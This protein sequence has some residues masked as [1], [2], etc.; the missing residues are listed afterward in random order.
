MPFS[1]A[2]VNLECEGRVMQMTRTTGSCH[3]GC[4]YRQSRGHGKS[5]KAAQRSN[6]ARA[7]GIFTASQVGGMAGPEVASEGPCGLS[8]GS[9]IVSSLVGG[10]QRVWGQGQCSQS[11]CLR[12]IILVTG[13]RAAT[14]KAI[15]Q[16]VWRPELGTLHG[17][18]V[19]QQHQK[20]HV[21]IPDI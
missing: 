18:I 1:L 10:T 4:V 21:Y 3:S 8:A 2:Q 7:H 15:S 13:W 19:Q 6:E 9:W 16:P 5:G 20:N 14:S 17:L 12:K 11:S